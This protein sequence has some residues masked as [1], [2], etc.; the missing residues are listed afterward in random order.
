MSGRPES[1]LLQTARQEQIDLVA[2]VIHGHGALSRVLPG[3]V[4][5][6]ALHGAEAPVL[7]IRLQDVAVLQYLRQPRDA[8][9]GD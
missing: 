1:M 6:N 7:M 4:A 8:L 9:A 5:D 2:R 3:S